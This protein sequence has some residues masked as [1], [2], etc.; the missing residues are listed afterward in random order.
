[1]RRHCDGKDSTELNFLKFDP[2][3]FSLARWRLFR[4]TPGHPV[5]IPNGCE[6][7]KTDFSLKSKQRFLAPL[8]MT[9]A[10][11]TPHFPIATQSRVGRARGERACTRDQR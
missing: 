6:G 4:N 1:M 8:E 10:Q 9:E 3:A 7:S 2:L 11:Q 5:V